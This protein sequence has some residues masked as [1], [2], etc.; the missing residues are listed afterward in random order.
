VELAAG[1]DPAVLMVARADGGAW[2]E[3]SLHEW[4]E[5]R[6]EIDGDDLLG[7][8]IARGPAVGAGL[9]G[10]LRRKLDGELESGREAELEAALEIARRSG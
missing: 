1:T 5:V 10:A 8:G 2:I 6:L 7:A 9:G 4:S 3:R